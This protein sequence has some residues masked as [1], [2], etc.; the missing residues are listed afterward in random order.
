MSSL[1]L[2]AYCFWRAWDLVLG[3]IV[4]DRKFIQVGCL[5]GRIWEQDI[6]VKILDLGVVLSIEWR[7]ISVLVLFL[8]RPAA[9]HIP[10]QGER[11]FLYLGKMKVLGLRVWIFT[12]GPAVSSQ[13]P[14]LSLGYCLVETVSKLVNAGFLVVLKFL[15]IEEN[16]WGKKH[17][18]AL[19]M[20]WNVFVMETP[21]QR[22][23]GFLS[24]RVVVVF[25]PVGRVEYPFFLSLCSGQT[26]SPT[27]GEFSFEG[28]SWELAPATGLPVDTG[29]SH[30]GHLLG[31]F[32]CISYQ[33]PHR[34][35]SCFT[36]ISQYSAPLPAPH[37]HTSAHIS[38]FC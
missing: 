2:S 37:N 36:E 25:H 19:K 27:T 14:L 26:E 16:K 12:D 15:G 18:Q 22:G 3:K 4:M 8:L 20:F 5:T 6:C 32:W 9:A 31:L 1:C 11:Q 23:L 33:V 34:S 7:Y 30:V 24:Q 28:R 21:S 13:S 38:I 10:C 17:A 35:A 29:V